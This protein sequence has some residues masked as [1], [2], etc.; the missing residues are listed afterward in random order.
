MCSNYKEA[1]LLTGDWVRPV[2]G[3]WREGG[4]QR[5]TNGEGGLGNIVDS[6]AIDGGMVWEIAWD[7]GTKDLW[8]QCS[9]DLD[10]QIGH[11]SLSLQP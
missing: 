3:C 7:N 2:I 10:H 4:R 8:F 11:Q 9:G 6:L 1:D 5:V